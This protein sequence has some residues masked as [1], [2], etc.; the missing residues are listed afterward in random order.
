MP[1]FRPPLPVVILPLDFL[2]QIPILLIQLTLNVSDK[3]VHWKCLILLLLQ[4]LYANRIETDTQLQ[5][6][7]IQADPFQPRSIMAVV[8]RKAPHIGYLS[9]MDAPWFPCSFLHHCA[10]AH[11][12][13]TPLYRTASDTPCLRSLAVLHITSKRRL[14]AHL[15]CTLPRVSYGNNQGYQSTTCDLPLILLTVCM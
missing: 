9:L 8:E 15:T 10:S 2:V 13:L 14:S 12:R 6:S 4:A 1:W 3:K 11:I 5:T 7:T